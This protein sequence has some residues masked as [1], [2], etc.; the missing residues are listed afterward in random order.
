MTLRR[1]QGYSSE[2]KELA[3]QV[4]ELARDIDLQFAERLYPKAVSLEAIWELPF[5]LPHGSVRPEG[6]SIVSAE[7]LADSTVLPAPY[8]IHWAW[9]D[10]E[11][12][13][14]ALTGL[15]SGVKYRLTFLIFGGDDNG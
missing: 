1:K 14:K 3:E 11:V 15:T 10:G 8:A 5:T 13:I 7:N 6:V 9:D 4:G 2:P 12:V